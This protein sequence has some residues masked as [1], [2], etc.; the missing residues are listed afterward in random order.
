MTEEKEER[1]K[2]ANLTWKDYVAVIIA[3]LQTTLLPFIIMIL[4]LGVL[5][6]ILR[7]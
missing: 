1:E 4:V 5:W 3:S 6:F 2:I 7:H